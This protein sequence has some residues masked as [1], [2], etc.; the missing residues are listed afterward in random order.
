MLGARPPR[1]TLAAGLAVCLAVV[2]GARL[3]ERPR[4]LPLS[5]W[6]TFP[7]QPVWAADTPEG[8][9]TLEPAPDGELVLM[10]DRRQLTPD[11]TGAVA[12]Q[13]RLIASWH[14][15]PEGR[16]SGVRVLL[17]GQLTPHRSYVLKSLGA[18]RIDR[19]AAWHA[20]MPAIEGAALRRGRAAHRGC[21]RAR[22]K[23][24]GAWRAAPSTS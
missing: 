16:R 2:A 1:L 7:P 12:D 5:P 9:L 3:L 24:S 13:E 14:M 22:R 17:V 8:L 11:G 19:T 6:R 10:L 20:S 23:P 18:A 21:A 15:L 4:A